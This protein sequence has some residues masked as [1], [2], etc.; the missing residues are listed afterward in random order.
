[1]LDILQREEEGAG[2]GLHESSGRAALAQVGT[3]S[4]L[5]GKVHAEPAASANVAAASSLRLFRTREP[6]A[7]S[8]AA[9]GGGGAAAAVE[10]E[11]RS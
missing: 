2:A 1:M 3:R 11:A 8:V 7:T 4:K 10:A 6:L 5:V 9:A